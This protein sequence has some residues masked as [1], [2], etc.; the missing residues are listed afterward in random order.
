MEQN[1]T[2]ELQENNLQQGIVL[3]NSS[4]YALMYIALL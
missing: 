4:K 3:K 1:L 2:F